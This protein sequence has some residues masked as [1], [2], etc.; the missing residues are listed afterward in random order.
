MNARGRARSKGQARVFSPLPALVLLMLAVLTLPAAAQVTPSAT[1]DTVTFSS[2]S[3]CS[4]SI[5]GF[6]LNIPSDTNVMGFKFDIL[7][8]GD[9]FA[10]D[11]S[12]V[13]ESTLLT[14]G[15][16]GSETYVFILDGESLSSRPQAR[17]TV[18]GVRMQSNS[19][20]KGLS[21][22]L[23]GLLSGLKFRKLNNDTLFAGRDTT[24][25]NKDTIYITN[26]VFRDQNNDTVNSSRTQISLRLFLLLLRRGADFNGDGSV[27]GDDYDKILRI[28]RG[29]ETLSGLPDY[30][31]T[32]DSSRTYENRTSDG[33]ISGEDIDIFLR[34]LRSLES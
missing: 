30:G 6:R 33:I 34:Y 9:T 1:T 21:N 28:A 4:T 10:V 2:A 15:A 24:V 5:T 32:D 14:T 26:F 11:T 8:P 18:I 25:Q 27:T 19:A 29:L 17:L 3:G 7:F 20:N 22:A 12:A 16:G 31:T 23:Y 13:T